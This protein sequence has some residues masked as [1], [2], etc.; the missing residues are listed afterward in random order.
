MRFKYIL[1]FS[2]LVLS[3]SSCHDKILVD[4]VV[5]HGKIYTVDSLFTMAEAFAVKDGKIIAIG[6]NEDILMKYKGIDVVNAKGYPV[7]PG[8]IDAHA[9][10]VGYGRS[11]FEVNLYDCKSWDEVITRVQTFVQ[12][13]P[14]EKWIRGRGWDQ[15][16]FPGQAYPDNVKLS[17]TFPGK[18]ILLERVDGHAAIASNAALELSTI[19]T[20][21]TLQGGTIEVKDGKVTGL[22]I[23]NAVD[24]VSRVVPRPVK[25]DYKKWLDAAQNRSFE[26]GLTTITDCGLMYYEAEMIDTLQRDSVLKMRVYVML[27]DSASNFQRYLGKKPYKTDKLYIKGVKA[28]ADGALGSRGACLLQPYSD[29]PGWMGFLLNPTSHYDSL[30]AILVNTDFQMCTHAIGDSG[31][32]MV[33]RIYNKYLKGKND[34]RWRIEH[35]QIVNKEDFNM[36]GSASVIPSVQPTHATSD[37]YWAADRLGAERL[38]GGYAYKQLL[39]QNG[40]IA[41]GTDFPVEDISPVKTFYAAVARM[42]G[43]GS[44]K[45][46]F[47]PENKLTREQA[48]KGMTIWAAKANCME[49]ETGSLE[50]GKKADFIIVNNDLM[51]APEDE[52]LETKVFTTFV[53]GDRVY[54]K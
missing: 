34:K 5:H 52:L 40:W 11:L 32:R 3:L 31:N 54:G 25:A 15:N 33:L 14:N 29:K 18:P 36:F 24:L 26:Q 1:L 4:V 49:Q 45:G 50:I 43:K 2:L 17:A 28:Y 9:H 41:L 13:N 51:L 27:T 20:T 10:F 35:A 19:T 44:P 30:A 22:L 48:L 23:D 38:K 12:A 42:D 16:K 47:Q 46:G 53:G 21:S 37:M 8:F 7:Y 39:E 6:K